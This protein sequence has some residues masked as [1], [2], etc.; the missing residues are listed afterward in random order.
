[1][2]NDTEIEQLVE[3]INNAY[4]EDKLGAKNMADKVMPQIL[5]LPANLPFVMIRTRLEEI[6]DN[7]NLRG[8]PQVIKALTQVG[9]ALNDFTN[10]KGITTTANALPSEGEPEKLLQRAQAIVLSRDKANHLHEA[11]K[12]LVRLSKAQYDSLDAD[13]CLMAVEQYSS[14]YQ[15]ILGLLLRARKVM[16]TS[17]YSKF[18]NACF[19]GDDERPT[20][21]NL[22][23][24]VTLFE[25]YEPLFAINISEKQTQQDHILQQCLQR[26]GIDSVIKKLQVLKAHQLNLDNSHTWH[27]WQDSSEDSPAFDD[28][29]KFIK[30][31]DSL[32]TELKERMR[33]LLDERYDKARLSVFTH[34]VKQDSKT[35]DA[36]PTAQLLH[37]LSKWQENKIEDGRHLKTVFAAQKLANTLA[38]ETP[39]NAQA[40][41]AQSIP[42]FESLFGAFNKNNHG[43]IRISLMHSI[44]HSLIKFTEALQNKC[45]SIYRTLVS[46][47]GDI[48]KEI[49]QLPEKKRA[50]GLS[51]KLRAMKGLTMELSLVAKPEQTFIHTGDNVNYYDQLIRSFEQQYTGSWLKYFTINR[52]RWQQAQTLFEGLKTIADPT[53]ELQHQDEFYKSMLTVIENTQQEIIDNDAENKI[54]NK[55]GYSRLLDISQQL[56]LQVCKDIIADPSLNKTSKQN[57]QNWLV[58]QEKRVVHQLWQRL[59]SNHPIVPELEPYARNTE[60]PDPAAVHRY[61]TAIT[62]LQASD[63]PK[64]VRYLLPLLKG[65]FEITKEMEIQAMQAKHNL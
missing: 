22:T 17:A 19:A 51:Q 29:I 39:E 58:S 37:I 41:H 42:T 40:R 49:S 9:D 10:R 21:H 44:T 7:Q 25:T 3:V 59:P 62:Q 53:K 30:D 15:D 57:A 64:E 65:H 54:P 27:Q 46:E 31:T 28:Q 13:T 6:A 50:I 11:E 33:A 4:D 20:L 47:V 35:T 32:P 52:T 45:W 14:H 2:I 16:E 23:R 26:T 60:N 61:K 43:S 12:I 24:I 1:M 18:Y 48:K 34:L 36:I 5:S 55:K 63:L 8:F 56:G 38:T